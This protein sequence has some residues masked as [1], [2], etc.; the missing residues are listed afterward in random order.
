MSIDLDNVYQ[1]QTD[2]QV[3]FIEGDLGASPNAAVGAAKRQFRE[4]YDAD[5]VVAKKMRETRNGFYVMTM[6]KPE[7]AYLGKMALSVLRDNPKLVADLQKKDFA[8][9]DAAAEELID[10]VFDRVRGSNRFK[11][12]EVQNA[13]EET[14]EAYAPVVKHPNG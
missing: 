8:L 12:K 7:P 11:L 9:V 4:D 2:V 13:L 1:A 3:Y 6:A 5:K 10:K 14:L